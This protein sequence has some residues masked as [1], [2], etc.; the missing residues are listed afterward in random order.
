MAHS[1]E[2]RASDAER[3]A[4]AQELRDHAAAGRLEP[5]EL[6][7]RLGRAY[8]ARTHGELAGLT[9]DLPAAA[10]APMPPAPKRCEL[11]ERMKPVA[12][13]WAAFNLAA[14]L[15]W[16]ATGDGVTDF[17]PKWVLLATTVIAVLRLGK[18]WD[19]DHGARDREMG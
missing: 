17:W 7:E 8:S 12:A 5:D 10:A 13:R 4:V 19:D 6:E 3:E 15:V 18:A 14:I 1:P 9:T 2:L 11:P 16:A